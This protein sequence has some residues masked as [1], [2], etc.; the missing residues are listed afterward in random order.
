[1]AKNEP[2]ITFSG[3]MSHG[4]ILFLA[5]ILLSL[6]G[7]GTARYALGKGDCRIPSQI[8]TLC[9]EV[10]FDAIVCDSLTSFGSGCRVEGRR[11]SYEI[12][13]MPNGTVEADA[14]HTTQVLAPCWRKN[15]CIYNE[16]SAR[17]EASGRSDEAGWHP[18]GWNILIDL[19]PCEYSPT[20][21]EK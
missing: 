21:T 11:F 1:M 18:G 17:C 20:I 13:S 10:P 6:L 19:D 5:L 7:W 8:E 9:T 4:R 2:S 16:A 15:F 3:K 14:G 12:N